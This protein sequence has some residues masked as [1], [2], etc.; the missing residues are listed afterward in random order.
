MRQW[1]HFSTC[2]LVVL[3]PPSLQVQQ[4]VGTAHD[5]DTGMKLGT[6]QPMGPLTLAGGLAKRPRLARLQSAAAALG[7]NGCRNSCGFKLPG[8]GVAPGP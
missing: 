4:G 1:L 7:F 3:P 2:R 6:N 8:V 5:I